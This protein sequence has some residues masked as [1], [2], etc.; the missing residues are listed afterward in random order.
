VYYVDGILYIESYLH[1][2][3]VKSCF[4]IDYVV[5]FGEGLT[6]Y[7][8]KCIFFCVGVK[9]YINIY[10]LFSPFHSYLLVSLFL[11]RVLFG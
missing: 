1:L 11:G 6:K 10:L 7:Y 2:I 3:H 4:V 8:E 5:N 9:Y